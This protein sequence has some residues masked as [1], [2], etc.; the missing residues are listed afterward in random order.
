MEKEIKT[1]FFIFGFFYCLF[2][3]AGM[4]LILNVFF[5]IVGMLLINQTYPLSFY[6]FYFLFF[7]GQFVLGLI[8]LIGPFWIYYRFFKNGKNKI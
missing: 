7:L 6:I 4:H 1:K 8:Y 3:I 5:F 2:F